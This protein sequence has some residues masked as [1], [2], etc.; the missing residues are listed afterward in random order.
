M[1]RM[2]LV[3]SN[4]KKF[5]NF[6]LTDYFI[7]AWF[8]LITIALFFFPFL[9][10]TYIPLPDKLEKGRRW[11]KSPVFYCTVLLVFVFNAWDVAYFSYT[12][13]RTSFDYFV[14]M[15][16]NTET[17]SLAGD[18][19]LEFW[20]LIVAFVISILFVAR[21]YR[22]VDYPVLQWKEKRHWISFVF[23]LAM[24][25]LVGRG[26]FQLKPIGIIEATNYSSLE[27]APAVLNS[28]FT[29]VKTWNMKGVEIG[30]AHV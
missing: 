27:N 23:I 6:H 30:R 5:P 20:W 9:I 29:L 8:D 26:G 13:K 19:I 11:I 16:T 10:L 25:V 7:G 12:A 18:F 4:S 15:L 3:F 17:S 21:F 1:Y 28:A 22:K 24:S 14:Y 2:L